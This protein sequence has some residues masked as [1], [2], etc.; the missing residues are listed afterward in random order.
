[1]A[2]APR[3]D[4]ARAW[5]ALQGHFEAHGRDLDLREAF[6]RD[7][8]RFKR[9]SLQAPEVFADL[10]KNRWDLA[11][12]RFLL[13]LARECQLEQR[14]DAM[15]AGQPINATEGRAVLHTALRAPRG[16]APF[17]DEVHS[18]L[19]AML[20]F[21]EHDACAGRQPVYRHRQYRHRWF[22]PRAGHGGS[23][24]GAFCPPRPALP[25]RQQCGRP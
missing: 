14:R 6:A 25:L 8:A 16:A 23:G 10:S 1:M 17:S 13:D 20:A 11:T 2:T 24:V 3:C 7:P 9:L 4:Q 22:R 18:V 5:T 21:V 19:D 15:L 12:Q